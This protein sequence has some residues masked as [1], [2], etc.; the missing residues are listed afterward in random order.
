MRLSPF[1]LIAL[2]P[3][4]TWASSLFLTPLTTALGSDN[5]AL[6][7]SAWQAVVFVT[8]ATLAGYVLGKAASEVI[9]ESPRELSTSEMLAALREG[10]EQERKEA[11]RE[12]D[13]K[14]E[15]TIKPGKFALGVA[16]GKRTQV[17]HFP[18]GIT[19]D[20]LVSFGDVIA[21][22]EPPRYRKLKET[23]D[24]TQWSTLRD[25]LMIAEINKFA[26]MAEY[27][28][29]RDEWDVT[30]IGRKLAIMWRCQ[31]SPTPLL[32]ITKKCMIEG[33]KTKLKQ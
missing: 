20:H 17:F 25:W 28:G 6:S 27:T 32:S 30:P 9:T 14:Y 12:P 1:A 13:H 3:A 15:T 22:G 19:Y 5:P 21:R 33:N 2:P 26:I 4:W 31:V 16:N 8:S 29:G 7:A 24:H 10:R 18:A 23:F 11:E